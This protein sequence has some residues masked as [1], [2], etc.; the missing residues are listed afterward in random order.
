M[1]GIIHWACIMFPTKQL[2]EWG[3]GCFAKIKVCLPDN[4][5]TTTQSEAT[6]IHSRQAAAHMHTWHLL[7]RR[8]DVRRTGNKDHSR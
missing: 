7:T 5:V 1:Y 8:L 2:G 4:D 3:G 6:A